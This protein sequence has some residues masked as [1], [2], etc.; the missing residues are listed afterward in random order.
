MSF[1][2]VVLAIM[3]LVAV[4]IVAL[5]YVG[6]LRGYGLVSG[7]PTQWDHLYP[8]MFTVVGV[9]FSIGLVSLVV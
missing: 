4:Q 1:A 2:Y 5:S 8:K 7:S 3:A 9:L 6:W